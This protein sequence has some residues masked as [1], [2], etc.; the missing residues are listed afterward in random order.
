MPCCLFYFMFLLNYLLIYDENWTIW[1]YCPSAPAHKLLPTFRR[2]RF[3]DS[4]IE[5][6][7]DSGGGG[8]GGGKVKKGKSFLSF[9]CVLL[10]SIPCLVCPLVCWS[11][12]LSHLNLSDVCV[13]STSML[14]WKKKMMKWPQICPLPTC[15]PCIL[16]CFLIYSIS[17][18]ISLF[19]LFL[20]LFLPCGDIRS[21]LIELHRY[22]NCPSMRLA[23]AWTRFWVSPRCRTW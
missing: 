8:L 19:F 7:L 5:P 23:I 16:P 11:V 4:G 2:A 21:I 12:G 9:S 18:F 6:H 10:D 3:W 13:F 20:N 22:V 1:I 14:L 15:T 17:G